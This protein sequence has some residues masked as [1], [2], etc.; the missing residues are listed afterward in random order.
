[1]NLKEMIDF[2]NEK[3]KDKPI[4]EVVGCNIFRSMSIPHS[5]YCY[6]HTIY[7]PGGKE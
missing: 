2:V 4:C 7:N 6:Y 1:M 3:T 5:P